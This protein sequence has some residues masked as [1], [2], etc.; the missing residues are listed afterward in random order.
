[1]RHDDALVLV[2]KGDSRQLVFEDLPLPFTSLRTMKLAPSNYPG[3]VVVAT[4]QANLGHG[5]K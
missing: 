2:D 1:M 5:L 4:N 3:R